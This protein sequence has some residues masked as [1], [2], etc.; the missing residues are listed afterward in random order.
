MDNEN[1]PNESERCHNSSYNLTLQEQEKAVEMNDFV[2]AFSDLQTNDNITALALPN[3]VWIEIFTYLSYGDLKQVSLVCKGWCQL[4]HA[5]LLRG[6]TRLVITRTNVRNIYELAKNEGL[7]YESV[8]V[9]DGWE[10]FN[11]TECKFLLKIFKYSG[12]TITK[13]KLCHI[14]PLI[15]LDNL[16]PNLEEFDLSDAKD[17]KNWDFSKFSNIKSVRMPEDENEDDYGDDEC[18]IILCGSLFT[19]INVLAPRN[20]KLG[21]R[22]VASCVNHLNMLVSYASSLRWLDIDLT[23]YTQNA[24]PLRD[25][26]YL[27]DTFRKLTHLEELSLVHCCD[28]EIAKIVLESLPTENRIKM[29][30]LGYSYEEEQFL[31]L[32]MKKWPIS[33]ERLYLVGWVVTE[34]VASQLEL[35]SSKYRLIFSTRLGPL[36]RDFFFRRP[37]PKTNKKSIELR[38]IVLD[39]T[40]SG[41]HNHIRLLPN[42]TTL[43][44][45]FRIGMENDDIMSYIFQYLTH[46]RYLSMDPC[47]GK[48]SIQCLCSKPSISN[49][50]GLQ[51]L[52]SCLCPIKVLQISNSNFQFKELTTLEV[53]SCERSGELSLLTLGHISAYFPALEEFYSSDLG[54]DSVQ[55]MR[56]IFPRL[57]KL[58]YRR[59]F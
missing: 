50:K 58:N 31:E 29:I 27:Q 46:L 26:L 33:L 55:E 12:P 18:E 1:L 47:H 43:E 16:L 21:I 37:P 7:N 38:L 13:L 53:L 39:S 9:D 30:A 35:L 54:Y 22:S 51:T 24:L 45:T 5:T 41:F 3:E 19:P 6:R 28:K 17:I 8:L 56:R 34:K 52:Y 49:L 11:G 10:E 15:V 32:I 57:R 23:H 25:R 42:V 2:D 36:P 40:E 20:R 4:V 44:I 14:P 48:V 59:L